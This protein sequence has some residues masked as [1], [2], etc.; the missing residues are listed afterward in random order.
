MELLLFV[1]ALRKASA[2]RI[3][4][5]IP[6]YGYARQDR[7]VKA[8]T[9]ISAADVARLIETQG[10]DR[11]VCVDLHAAQI[12]GFFGNSV[13]V[14]NLTG[15]VA[16]LEYLMEKMDIETFDNTVIVSPDAGGVYR[17]KQ[18]RAGI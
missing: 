8:R 11:V 14:D 7:K 6:Y 5:V 15:G 18:F 17:A 4:A 13:N 3:T 9:P 12:M 10:V 2:Q 16:G 1:S